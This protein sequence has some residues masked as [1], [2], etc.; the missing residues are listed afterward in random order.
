[1]ISLS[2]SRLSD[3]NQCPRKFVLKY[4]EKKFPEEKE[5]SIHLIKGEELH[6]QLEDYVLAKNGQAQM[7]VGFSPAVKDALPLVDSFFAQGYTV[8]PEAQVSAG[9]DWKPLEWFD[10]N[11]MYRA[12]WDM[13]A[14]KPQTVFI[15]DYKSG[16]VYDYTSEYGQLHL[17]ACMA[18]ER[19]S[20][21]TEVHTAYIYLEHKKTQKIKLIRDED[22]RKSSTDVLHAN[23]RKHFEE[24]F[25]K[26]QA[27]KEWKPTPNEF[28]KWCPANKIQCQFSRKL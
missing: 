3:Y 25:E 11:T 5:K 23:V 17:S 26:V 16:K 20:D 8:Y 13:I 4:I 19:F 9:R 24:E 6:K 22:H 7:P 28:C 15:G 21:A 1:M 2:W 12:I 27:E 18:M 10:K 14:I